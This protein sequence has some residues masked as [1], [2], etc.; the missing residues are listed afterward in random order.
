MTAPP[1]SD[2]PNVDVKPEI[3]VVRTSSPATAEGT[4]AP[5][6]PQFI[7]ELEGGELVVE[8]A[9]FA[10]FLSEARNEDEACALSSS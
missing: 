4:L 3:P 1:P 9:L 2:D 10:G 7:T 8:R 5:H 6:G